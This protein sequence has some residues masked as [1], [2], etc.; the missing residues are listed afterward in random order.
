MKAILAFL[1]AILLTLSQ[2]AKADTSEYEVYNPMGASSVPYP[3][4]DLNEIKKIKVK[5]STPIHAPEQQLDELEL[6][7]PNA[8]NLVAK[9]FQKDENAY[10]YGGETVYKAIVEDAWVYSR[11]LVKVTSTGVI[12]GGQNLKVELEVIEVTFE[13]NDT[14]DSDGLLIYSTDGILNDV[15]PD[16]VADIEAIN[17]EGDELTL[18]LYQRAKFDEF[19]GD[20][21]KIKSNWMGHGERTL[22]IPAPIPSEEY[23]YFRAT[24]IEIESAVMPDGY[25]AHQFRIKYEDPMGYAEYTQL[26]PLQPYIDQAYQSNP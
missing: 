6:V 5:T 7:F 21:F 4:L 18:T 12:T 19:T 8:T 13:L 24:D 25:I 11:L 14:S 3:N 10:S 15:T 1:T 2:A 20:G 22:N 16:S 26:E 23:S 17:Y 9:D